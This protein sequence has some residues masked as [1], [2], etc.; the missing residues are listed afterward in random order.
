MKKRENMSY[1]P[2]DTTAHQSGRNMTSC[3][4]NFIIVSHTNSVVWPEMLQAGKIILHEIVVYCLPKSY[5]TVLQWLIVIFHTLLHYV[6]YILSKR[7]INIFELSIWTDLNQTIVSYTCGS[8]I[9]AW[10]TLKCIQTAKVWYESVMKHLVMPCLNMLLKKNRNRGE[11]LW[12]DLSQWYSSVLA[13]SDTV[14]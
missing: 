7:F 13:N 9:A 12:I 8:H 4:S 10:H 2:G 14:C 11:I 1:I 5:C 3:K 6:L